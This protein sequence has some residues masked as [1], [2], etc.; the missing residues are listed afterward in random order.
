MRGERGVGRMKTVPKF[1][2]WLAG[3]EG[4]VYREVRR[5]VPRV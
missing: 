5:V 3:G 4:H 1:K 2:M